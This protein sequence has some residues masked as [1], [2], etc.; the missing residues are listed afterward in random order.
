MLDQGVGHLTQA[1]TQLAASSEDT[2]LRINQQ[3]EETD[4]VATAMNQMT[5]TVHDVARNAEEAAL[6]ETAAAMNLDV[7]LMKM[8]PRRGGTLA[9]DLLR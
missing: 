4:Q 6:A 5:A 1:A 2:K 9:T 8:S 7:M 3:R